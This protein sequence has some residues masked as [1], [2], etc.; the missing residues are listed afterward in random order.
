[1]YVKC[2]GVDSIY[3]LHNLHVYMIDVIRTNPILLDSSTPI[4]NIRRLELTLFRLFGLLGICCL[5]TT[6]N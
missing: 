1:M 3:I 4:K 5:K 2:V 6:G